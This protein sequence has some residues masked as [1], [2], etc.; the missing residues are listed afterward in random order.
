MGTLIGDMAVGNPPLPTSAEFV[1]WCNSYCE[2]LMTEISSTTRSWY[3]FSTSGSD[4]T[5]D[6]S[7][8]N[9]WETVDK[10]N[11][12]LATGDYVGVKFKCGDIFYTDTQL[13]LDN[14]G[15]AVGNYGTGDHPQIHQEG[16]LIPA[17][18][19]WTAVIG[20]IYYT[21]VTMNAG[22]DDGRLVIVGNT[23]LS[24]VKDTNNTPAS[25][26]YFLDTA[27]N[28]VYVN[29]D[30]NPTGTAF[31]VY[32]IRSNTEGD[33]GA[34]LKKDMTWVDGVD[35]YG[36]G[37]RGST[38]SGNPQQIYGIKIVTGNNSHLAVASNCNNYYFRNHAIS[39]YGSNGINHIHRC[40]AGWSED[41]DGKY[42]NV[43]NEASGLLQGSVAHCVGEGGCMNGSIG[44]TGVFFSHCEQ[45][46]VAQRFSLCMSY[47]NTLD[48]SFTPTVAKGSEI[49]IQDSNG[50]FDGFPGSHATPLDGD[51][52]DFIVNETI[53]CDTQ[54]SCPM[55]S[56]RV[57]CVYDVAGNFGEAV[58]GYDLNALNNISVALINCSLT[59]EQLTSSNDYFGVWHFVSAGTG[60]R[61]HELINTYIKVKAEANVSVRVLD[62]KDHPNCHYSIDDCI[63][64]CDSE[65]SN[66]LGAG[67][68]NNTNQNHCVVYGIDTGYAHI[69]EVI[70]AEVEPEDRYPVDGDSWFEAGSTPQCEVDYVGRTR[71]AT[72]CSLGRFEPKPPAKRKSLHQAT[73]LA[74][75]V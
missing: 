39:M 11:D 16:I 21:P 24:L 5:G 17:D 72:A 6:G 75:D 50:H 67:D 69:S 23:E 12:T 22:T 57:N 36:F 13:L 46:P 2:E 74:R 49:N 51:R 47:N 41:S 4:T 55:W 19:E 56:V 32:P 18:A 64:V 10:A 54:E 40:K 8:D 66:N 1:P 45:D 42:F 61:Y 44:T 35:F 29:I 73:G 26:Q 70:E 7:I 33:N 31:Y 48:N 30:K 14:T 37:L 25:N 38:T 59:I 63:F 53:I 43:H 68:D 60:I 71:N 58:A 3:Y 65:T 28:R 52:R 15:N 62:R 20:N 34:Y 27:N 9:P